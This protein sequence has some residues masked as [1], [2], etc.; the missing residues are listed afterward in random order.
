MGVEGG[1]GRLSDVM[2]VNMMMRPLKKNRNKR[3]IKA[4][5]E[6]KLIS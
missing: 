4:G 6:L 1:G 2:V 5:L 3:F